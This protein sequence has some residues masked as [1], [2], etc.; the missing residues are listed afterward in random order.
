MLQGM[1]WMQ[2]KHLSKSINYPQVISL[3]HCNKG[4]LV[5][6]SSH[7]AKVKPMVPRIGVL[8]YC[9]DV[10]CSQSHSTQSC[11]ISRATVSS[12]C[13]YD[14]QLNHKQSSADIWPCFLF[15][16]KGLT[17][18][19][20]EN[21]VTYCLSLVPIQLCSSLLTFLLG[22]FGTWHDYCSQLP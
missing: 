16:I 4:W 11:V 19:E 17:L 14:Y 3:F 2:V 8:P 6:A 20:L 21:H 9:C 7:C 5:D 10:I 12:S 15:C 18:V 13:R 1:V 22:E